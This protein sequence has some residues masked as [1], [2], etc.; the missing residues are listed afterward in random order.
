MMTSPL[1]DVAGL[2]GVTL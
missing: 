2:N 1:T